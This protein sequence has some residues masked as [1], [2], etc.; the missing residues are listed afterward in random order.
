MCR[1]LGDKVTQWF[2][3]HAFA[4]QRKAEDTTQHVKTYRLND[5]AAHPNDQPQLQRKDGESV[6]ATAMWIKTEHLAFVPYGDGQGMPMG[7]FQRVSKHR[8]E[9]YAKPLTVDVLEERL[10][11]E[12]LRD[13][14]TQYPDV[15]YPLR[16][17]AAGAPTYQEQVA[18]ETGRCAKCLRPR[19]NHSQS[20]LYC[21]VCL[22]DL[23]GEQA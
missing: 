20:K 22:V 4:A 7:G 10:D 1:A 2:K 14:E 5:P 17:L 12:F 3:P 16:A 19:D 13:I 21:P 15:V 9:D 11:Q 18:A 23:K 6:P 8:E